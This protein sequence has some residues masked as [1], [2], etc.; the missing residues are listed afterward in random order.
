MRS[1]GQVEGLGED[2]SR[3]ISVEQ[4]GREQGW[5]A[6]KVTSYVGFLVV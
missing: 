4:V 1:M 5:R 3:I 6:G 2:S